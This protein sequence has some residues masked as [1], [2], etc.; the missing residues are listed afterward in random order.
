MKFEMIMEEIGQEFNP[1]ELA[2]L[3]VTSK[4]EGFIRDLFCVIGLRH[5]DMCLIF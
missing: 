5:Q 1:D 3:A 2:Y 4:I